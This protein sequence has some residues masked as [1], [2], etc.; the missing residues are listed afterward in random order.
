M[1]LQP[2][3]TGEEVVDPGE[4]I[5]DDSTHDDGAPQPDAE[6]KVQER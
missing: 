5:G 3:V 2:G 6:D 4:I 1:L